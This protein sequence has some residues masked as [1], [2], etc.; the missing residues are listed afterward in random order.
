M[1]EIAQFL[2][3]NDVKVTRTVY[4]RF[5]PD[6][7]AEAAAALEYDDLGSVNRRSIYGKSGS[8]LKTTE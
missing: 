6:F 2:G 4:A 7:L 1:D 5:S 8:H 3:H